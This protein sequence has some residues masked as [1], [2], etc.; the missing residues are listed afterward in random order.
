MKTIGY[1]CSEL[2]HAYKILEDGTRISILWESL[3]I[4]LI[5]KVEK[6]RLEKSNG[7]QD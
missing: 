2:G 5:Q 6:D 1:A 7:K 4:E 3:P